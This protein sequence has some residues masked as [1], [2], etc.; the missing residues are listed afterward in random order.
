MTRAAK[1]SVRVAAGT[2][3]SAGPGRRCCVGSSKTIDVA[4][5]LGDTTTLADP[6]VVDEIKE[7]ATAE[8]AEEQ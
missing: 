8:A 5:E 6:T 4:K 1:K 2:S 7:R 3:S